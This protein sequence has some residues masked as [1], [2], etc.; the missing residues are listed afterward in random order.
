[1]ITYNNRVL[2]E[3]NWACER[4]AMN[5]IGLYYEE[6][7]STPVKKVEPTSLSSSTQYFMQ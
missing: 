4:V 3:I 7:Q 1:M 2:G 6:E 5:Y